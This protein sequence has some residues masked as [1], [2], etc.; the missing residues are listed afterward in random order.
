MAGNTAG[1]ALALAF[2]NITRAREL[3]AFRF[4]YFPSEMYLR[5]LRGTSE[6]DPA[7]C[8]RWNLS[9]DYTGEVFLFAMHLGGIRAIRDYHGTWSRFVDVAVG[10]DTRNYRPIPDMDLVEPARQDLALGLAFN[11]QGFCDWLLENTEAHRVRRALHGFFDVVQV[12]FTWQPVATW[13]RDRPGRKRMF[14]R[15]PPRRRARLTAR[16]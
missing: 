2:D 16:T 6:C 11:A 9:E 1:A 14:S 12:P 13:S 10:F 8:S 15:L 4:H 7:H 5:H 3:F